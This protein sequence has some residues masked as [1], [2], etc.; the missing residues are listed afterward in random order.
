MQISAKRLGE[1][2]QEIAALK[3]KLHPLEMR[4]EKEKARRDEI[5]RLQKKKKQLQEKLEVANR[6]NEMAQAAEL[7]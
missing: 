2:K 1:V 5:S 4:H 3:D 7:E 6:R